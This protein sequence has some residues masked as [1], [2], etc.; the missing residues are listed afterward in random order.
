MQAAHRACGCPI[1]GTVQSEAGWCFEQPGLME[2][3]PAHVRGVNLDN[4]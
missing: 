4:P 2:A 3:V 1:T